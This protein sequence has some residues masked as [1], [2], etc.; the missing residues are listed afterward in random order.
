MRIHYLAILV[1]VSFANISAY[2]QSCSLEIGRMQERVDAVIAATAAA[3][4]VAREGTFATMHRQPTP[5]SVAGAEERLGEGV[6]AQRALAA[7]ARARAAESAGDT[8][9]CGHALKEA[10][11]ALEP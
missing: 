2:A 7:I 11:L 8:A 6:P 4:G 5:S 3:G 10:Q 1:V 9:A